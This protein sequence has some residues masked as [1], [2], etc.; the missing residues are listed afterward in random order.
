[1]VQDMQ[2]DPVPARKEKLTLPVI[3][4]KFRTLTR[5]LLNL[6]LRLFSFLRGLPRR[7]GKILRNLDRKSVV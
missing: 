7:G 3:L 1:M 5:I 6:L 2:N 4:R